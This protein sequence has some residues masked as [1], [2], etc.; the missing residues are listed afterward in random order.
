[1]ATQDV[2]LKFLGFSLGTAMLILAGRLVDL[3]VVRH[4]ELSA[5]A[6]TNTVRTIARVLGP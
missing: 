3:Q 5:I 6:H 1:M 2:K 4:D